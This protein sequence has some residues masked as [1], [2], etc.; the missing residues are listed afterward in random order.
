MATQNRSELKKYFE[1][2]D[3]PTSKDFA[4]LIDSSINLLED[5]ISVANSKVGLGVT[6]PVNKLDIGGNMAIGTNLSG[7]MQAPPNGLAI[8]G[9]LS[10]GSTQSNEKLTIDGVISL[11]AQEGS[12]SKTNDFGKLFVKK[13][14]ITSILFNGSDNF[15]EINQ[16]LEALETLKQGTLSMW[17]KPFDGELRP[18]QLIWQGTGA[19]FQIGIGE[20]TSSF[21]DESLVVATYKN[22]NAHSASYLRK[23]VNFFTKNQWYHIV[24]TVG[25]SFTKMFID[26][27]EQ[28]VTYTSGNAQT[29]HQFLNGAAGEP[30]FIGKRILNKDP[31][32][33]VKGFI[34]EVSIIDRPL[35]SWD[36]KKLYDGGRRMDLRMSHGSNLVAYWRINETDDLPTIKDHSGNGL[37]GTFKGTI[38]ENTLS[39]NEVNTLYFKDGDGNELPLSDTSQA[40]S[41]RSLWGQ[42]GSDIYFEDGRVG[43]G[44]SDPKAHLHLYKDKYTLHGPNTTWGAYLQVGGN[45]RVTDHAS[46]VATNGNLHLDSRNG[47]YQTY[48]NYYSQGHTYINTRGG[49]VAIGTGSPSHKL[50]VNGNVKADKFFGQLAS[51]NNAYRLILQDDRNLV[52]YQS[53]GPVWAS[54]THLSDER[55]KTN[56]RPVKKQLD[57]LDKIEGFEFSWKDQSLGKELEFGLSAQQVEEVFP[58]LV[59][60]ING[61]KFVKYQSFIPVL[62]EAIKSQRKEIDDLKRFLKN[63]STES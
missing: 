4:D 8:E 50:H 34:D 2:G 27:I 52:I 44:T 25:E 58:H 46:V 24:V 5:D 63:K 54:N 41:V 19:Y 60:E 22:Q 51:N 43:I 42:K 6:K 21:E 3:T 16:N 38:D 15:I 14:K 53:S 30:L 11:A 28:S 12:P 35:S 37:H 39:T 49:N 17:Y 33:F 20:W 29:G 23:G 10:V 31:N 26:G 9:N 7:N 59:K 55:L 62:I 48:L 45:G 57:L 13:E 40:G 1:T 36:V 56:L 47:N 32:M 61:R 18:Q